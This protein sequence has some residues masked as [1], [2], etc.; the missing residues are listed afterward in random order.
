MGDYLNQRRESAT[1]RLQALKA[2]L[3][4]QPEARGVACVYVTGSFGRGEA[5]THSDIDLFIA[6]SADEDGTRRFSALNETCLKAD[7]I[8][9]TRREGFVEF[10]GDGEYLKHYTIKDLV[11]SLG[12][13]E[14]DAKNTFTARLLLLLESQ[15]LIGEDVH[16]QAIEAAIESYW[17]DYDGHQADFTPAFL[18]ND[19]LRLWRTFCVNYEA[20]TRAEP[21][22]N[23]AKRKLKN[24]KLKHSRLLTC[25]SGIAHLL[26]LHR[27]KRTVSPDD[28]LA[29]TL[30]TPTQRIENLSTGFG[31]DA[32]LVGEVL[33]RYEAFLEATDKP[34]ANLVEAF[35]DDPEFSRKHLEQAGQFGDVVARLLDAINAAPRFFR[36]LRV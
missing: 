15:P 13:S 19:I 2:Q 5:G 34:E 6:G 18:V 8:R 35:Q 31:V 24:Y 36:M 27:D 11:G 32:T 33:D 17:R 1:R 26:A 9:A 29:M 21:P 16:K 28:A 22:I 30:F 12:K 3:G 7:L 25:Y 4:E 23:K 14:D 20:R 10:S